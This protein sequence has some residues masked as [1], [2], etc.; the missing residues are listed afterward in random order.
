MDLEVVS[1][2][3]DLST[4]LKN[5]DILLLF[6]RSMTN[7]RRSVGP[8]IQPR[9]EWH[10]ERAICLR[11]RAH[12]TPLTPERVSELYLGQWTLEPLERVVQVGDFSGIL[13]EMNDKSP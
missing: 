2:T 8:I 12:H 9:P 13:L 11:F 7:A 1:V 10:Q 3:A 5:K 6:L 4:C